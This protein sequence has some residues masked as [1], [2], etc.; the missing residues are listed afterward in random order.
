MSSIPF[1]PHLEVVPPGPKSRALGERLK[2]AECAEVTYIADDFPI[3]W[4]R[5]QGNMVED[6][7]GNTYLD[8]TAAFA[9]ASVG[10]AHP[11]VVERVQAQAATLLHGMGDVHPTGLKV[12]LAEKLAAITPGALGRPIFATSGAEAVEAARK[13]CVM[14]TGKAN[15]LAFTGSYHGLTYGALEATSRADFRRP[16]RHQLAGTV[17]FVPYPYCYRCPLGRTYPDCGLACL[18][19]VR[20]KL[21]DPASGVGDVGGILMEPIQ[22]RGGTIVPPPGY[23]PALKALCEEFGILLILDEIF[24]GLGRTGRLFACEFEDVVP[25]LLAVGKALGGGMPISA[26][27]GLPAVMDQ[28]PASQGEALHTST[29]LGHPVACAAALTTLDVLET[30]GLPARAASMGALAMEKL[31][32]LQTR[33]PQLGDVRGR[34]LMIGLELVEDRQSRQ[35]ATRLSLDLMTWA[36][37]HGLLILP[38]GTHGNVIGLSPPLTIGVDELDFCIEVLDQGLKELTGR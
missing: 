37:R 11:R 29:F 33:H 32:D 18:N 36:L 30:E 16:F 23:L 38:E 34:G 9:V 3:F 28:W 4:A 31:R 22:G 19:L 10:H 24:C 12:E 5:A 15:L 27:V 14:A 25:D 2:A 17:D 26:C 8:F 35:P 13:S 1:P 6:V 7:D 20:Q 21:E